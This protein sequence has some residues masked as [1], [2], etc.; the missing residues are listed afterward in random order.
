M[1]AGD[2]PKV[3]VREREE[4]QRR[5]PEK[6]EPGRRQRRK[7]SCTTQEER[8]GISGLEIHECR[9]EESREGNGLRDDVEKVCTDAG[10]VDFLELKSGEKGS[11][12]VGELGR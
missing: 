9:R 5:G 1:A 8:A 3:N 7:S 2:N 10:V 11:G 6:I 12:G 4:K